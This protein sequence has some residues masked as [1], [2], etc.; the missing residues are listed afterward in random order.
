[1]LVKILGTIDFASAILLLANV[2]GIEPYT[3]FVFFCGGLLLM[4]GMFVFTGDF[5]SWLDLFSAIIL[6]LTLVFT[7]PTIL[8]WLPALLLMSKAVA[9]FI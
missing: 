6:F 7:L 3:S 2:F 9:S 1:M 4:K 8:I 5:L